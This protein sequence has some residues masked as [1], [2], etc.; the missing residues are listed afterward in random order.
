MHEGGTITIRTQMDVEK[1]R[2]VAR[3]AL[4]MQRLKGEV[5]SLQARMEGGAEEGVLVGDATAMQEVY[6]IIGAVTATPNETPVLFC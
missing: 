3:R 2:T 1:V 5:C 4:E 6:K